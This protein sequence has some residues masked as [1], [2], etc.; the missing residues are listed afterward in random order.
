MAR[1]RPCGATG[2]LSLEPTES[3]GVQHASTVCRDLF[4]FRLPSGTAT[5]GTIALDPV[6]LL[7][8]NHPQWAVCD[9]PV[10]YPRTRGRL[11]RGAERSRLLEYRRW[12]LRV[13][14]FQLITE[15]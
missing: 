2:T 1:A 10:R 5:R 12:L 9:G 7:L 15:G 13:F 14:D 4:G 11:S 3:E 6:L 8:L